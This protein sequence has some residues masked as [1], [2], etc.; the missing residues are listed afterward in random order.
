MHRALWTVVV[1][2]A[3]SACSSTGKNVVAEHLPVTPMFLSEDSQY[4]LV[5]VPRDG[6]YVLNR[7]I[8]QGIFEH[9]DS[10]W[11]ADLRA[12]Q[13]VGFERADEGKVVAVAGDQRRV[14]RNRHYQW[15]RRE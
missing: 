6:T 2:V 10:F 13:Q 1:A 9:D 7:V 4:R 5:S 14:L 11:K 8:Q 15:E 12:G 3:A